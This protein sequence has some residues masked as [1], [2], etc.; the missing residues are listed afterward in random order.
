MAETTSTTHPIRL[1][2]PPPLFPTLY[3]EGA[4]NISPLAQVIKFYLVRFDP[5][6]DGSPNF[7][8]Q[9]V[10]QVAMTIPGF[11]QMVLFFNRSLEEYAK[12]GRIDADMYEQLRK[13]AATMPL[14]TEGEKK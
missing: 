3:A 6:F 5:A 11:V 8:T 14:S 12:Q 10:A 9:P 13:A 4:A 2:Y 7:L 1:D